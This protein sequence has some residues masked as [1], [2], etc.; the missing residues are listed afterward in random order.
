MLHFFTNLFQ[1]FWDRGEFPNP[2]KLSNVIYLPKPGKE[3]YSQERSYRPICLSDILGKIFERIIARRLVAY[4]LKI[5]FF[6]DTQ[7]AYQSGADCEQAILDMAL[8]IWN[9]FCHKK[10]AAVGFIDLEGAFDAVWRDGL[11]YKLIK[12]GVNGRLYKVIESFLNN[13]F[14]RSFVNSTT[15]DWI[16]V[17]LRLSGWDTWLSMDGIQLAGWD[18]FLKKICL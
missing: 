12:L 17:V 2:W 9:G 11:K 8:D 6:N 18:T 15:T 14:A 16:K 13:R 4:L 3:T 10:V 1:T 7:Y 5:G